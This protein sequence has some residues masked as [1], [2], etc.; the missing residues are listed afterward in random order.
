M[1]TYALARTLQNALQ[2]DLKHLNNIQKRLLILPSS[3]SLTKKEQEKIIK[4]IN[5]FS[6]SKL[7]IT[8]LKS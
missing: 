6:L 8:F 1:E 3:T 7:L 4:I 2:T 5:D